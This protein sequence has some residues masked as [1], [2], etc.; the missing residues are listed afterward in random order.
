MKCNMTNQGNNEGIVFKPRR[1]SFSEGFS[2]PS[3]EE[4]VE[5]CKAAGIEVEYLTSGPDKGYFKT[6]SQKAATDASVIYVKLMLA[7]SKM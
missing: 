1:T 2:E 6:T 4:F 5:A 3:P 7:K